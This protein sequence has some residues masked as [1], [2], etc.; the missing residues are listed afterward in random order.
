LCCA[1]SKEP[2]Y[3]PGTC[4]IG[5]E[6]LAKRKRFLVKCILVTVLGVSYQLV[7]HSDKVLRL[8]MFIPFAVTAVAAQQVFY[9]FCYRFGL[10]G[11]YGFGELGKEKNAEED[12]FKKLDRKKSQRMIV[13]SVIIGIILSIAYYFL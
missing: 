7:F 12:E 2:D 11:L 8:L 10:T 1:V 5:N 4:N 9:K 6:Q 13:S 3:I